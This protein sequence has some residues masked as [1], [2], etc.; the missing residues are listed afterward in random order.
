MVNFLLVAMATILEARNLYRFFHADDEETQALRGVSLRVDAGEMV[1]V[2]GPSGSGKST[3]LACLAGTDEPDGGEVRILGE[4]I[5]R[6]PE[7]QRAA[8]RARC[9]GFLLQSDNLVEHLTVEGNILLAMR[10]A[11]KENNHRLIALLEAL[12][13]IDHRDACPE[14]LSGGEAA[15]AGLA[16]A[17]AAAPKIL[18][19]DEPTGEVDALTESWVLDLMEKHCQDGGAVIV[20][21]HSAVIANRARRV[22]L[23]ADGK[24][25]GD[26]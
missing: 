8:I 2:S 13:L 19:A 18:L 6:R 26:G 10:L 7:P 16:V 23:L 9:V 15:R 25:L 5:T 24:V 22:V 3:L 20:A 14:Q 11:G 17:L 12:G 4:R 21:T 1:A